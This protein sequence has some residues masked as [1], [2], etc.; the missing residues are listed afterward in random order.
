MK[1]A[2]LDF[3]SKFFIFYVMH[4][5]G[6]AFIKMCDSLINMSDALIN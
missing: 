1:Q 5:E 3:W 6:D 2:R 4:F